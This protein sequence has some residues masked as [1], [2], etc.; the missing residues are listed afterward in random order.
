MLE[1]SLLNS[2]VLQ[3]RGFG[4]TR[5][6]EATIC[7]ITATGI[8]VC[9]EGGNIQI[10]EGSSVSVDG[11]YINLYEAGT[12]ELN[13]T[14]K[15]LLKVS[16]NILTREEKE[17]LAGTSVGFYRRKHF[18]EKNQALYLM[19]FGPSD[20]KMMEGDVV[21]DSAIRGELKASFR[22]MKTPEVAC[23]A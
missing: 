7:G 13:E 1:I 17:T 20:G 8:H 15:S 5:G 11:D 14:E 9:T 10:F 18:F 16:K 3:M 4:L 2:T 22:V 12:R 19:G 23:I 21:R 6:T